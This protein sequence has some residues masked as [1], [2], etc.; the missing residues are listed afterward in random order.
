MTEGVQ[1]T[2]MWAQ[3][4]VDTRSSYD[5]YS[6]EVSEQADL[7][8]FRRGLAIAKQ[9]FWSIMMKLSPARRVA[10]LLAPLVRFP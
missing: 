5:F 9:F 6:R 4:R 3:F 8:G 7:K 10:L 2:Q 1:L